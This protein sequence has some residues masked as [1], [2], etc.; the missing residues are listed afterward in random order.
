MI[1]QTSLTG[2]YPPLYDINTSI[3]NFPQETQDDLVHRSITRAIADQIKLGLDILV[4]G[5]TRNDII[6]TFCTKLPGFTGNRL[7]Y[8]VNARVQPAEE[9]ITLADYL[10]AKELIGKRPLKAHITGPLTIALNAVVSPD[11]GY[12]SKMDPQFV[13]DVA[14]AI[15]HEAKALVAAGAEIVQIDEAVLS[16]GADLDITFAMMRRIIELGE[17]PYTVLHACGNV[18]KI[19]D[20]ILLHSPVNAVSFEGSWL[21]REELMYIDRKFMA[22]CGKQL[23]LGCVAVTDYKIEQ[24]R[25]V[26]SFIDQIVTRLGIDSIWA[27]MPNCGLRLLPYAVAYEKIQAMVTA[28]KSLAL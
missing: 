24:P 7:P 14:D 6:S 4:D 13:Q 15:G 20:N 5:Q 16:N 9:P 25:S 1:L 2:S 23:G 21:K 18:S 28:T 8:K 12:S 27:I 10:F 19:L 11:S 26:Q 22:G 3:L 17:I